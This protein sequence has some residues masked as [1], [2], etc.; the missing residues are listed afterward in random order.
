M[1]D[2]ELKFS[3]IMPTFNREKTLLRAIKSVLNQSYKNW[4]LI[5]IDDGSTDKT[6][7][8]VSCIDDNRLNY[9]HQENKGRSA[10]R[11]TGISLATGDFICFLDSDDIFY[12]DHLENLQEQIY[13][14]KFAKALFHTRYNKNINNEIISQPPQQFDPTNKLSQVVDD[15]FTIHSVAIHKEILYEEFFN[16][17]LIYWEDLDLWIRIALKYPIFKINKYTVEYIFHDSNTVAWNKHNLDEKLKTLLYFKNKYYSQLPYGYLKKNI[18]NVSMGIAGILSEKR[19]LPTALKYLKCAAMHKPSAL[20]TRYYLAII[21]NFFK[22][23]NNL[24]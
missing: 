7:E 4:E 15:I 19:D 10:A 8:V 20:F 21:K 11:N 18:Y 22:K 5:V 6:S 16:D 14:R 17:D 12:E 1:N 2:K 3:I 9:Y 24:R 23:N 13:Q